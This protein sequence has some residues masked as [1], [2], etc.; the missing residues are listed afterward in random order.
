M[1]DLDKKNLNFDFLFKMVEGCN[2]SQHG[3]MNEPEIMA[4]RK[5]RPTKMMHVYDNNL[6][7]G[8]CSVD[9]ELLAINGWLQPDGTLLACGWQQHTKTLNSIG[10]DIERDAVVAGN[11]KL[12]NMVWQIGRQYTKIVLTDAQSNTIRDWHELNAL[13]DEYFLYQL[14]KLKV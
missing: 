10:Y 3:L 1:S 5:P 8:G 11:V 6:P 4:P 13:S 14:A 12:S 2:L 7:D 9:H